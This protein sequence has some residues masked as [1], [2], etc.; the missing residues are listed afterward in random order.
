MII[1][2][3]LCNLFIIKKL[4]AVLNERKLFL[5]SF[6]IALFLPLIKFVFRA[7]HGNYGRKKGWKKII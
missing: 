2:L 5:P 4:L 3:I 7:V 1:F 6:L